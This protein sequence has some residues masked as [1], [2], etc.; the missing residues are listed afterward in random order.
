MTSALMISAG[1]ASIALGL[2][3][4]WSILQRIVPGKAIGAGAGM[5]NGLANG[6][7]AFSPIL[8]GYFIALSGSYI[9]GLMFLV[10]L[11]MAGAVCMIILSLQK[12]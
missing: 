9:G 2:P 10:G 8:I 11:A 4:S 3:S 1:I 5:M 7:S 12:Y 6:G